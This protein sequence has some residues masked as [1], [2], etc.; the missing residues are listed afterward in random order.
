MLI[1]AFPQIKIWQSSVV[2]L[3]LPKE[4]MVPVREGV[5]KLS[6]Q[7]AYLFEDQ[8]VPLT[9]IFVLSPSNARAS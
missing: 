5:D 9:Q 7:E 8:P 6:W 3:Q 4:T 1:P 2:G